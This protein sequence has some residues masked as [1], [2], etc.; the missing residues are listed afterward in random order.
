MDEALIRPGRV[1]VRARFGKA[2]KSQAQ[3]LFTKFFP[4]PTAAAAAAPLPD[5]KLAKST[6]SE[7]RKAAEKD[8]FVTDE[9][10]KPFLTEKFAPEVTDTTGGTT[11]APWGSRLTKEQ[12]EALAARFAEA[13]P[14]QTYSIAQLQ[15]FLMGYKKTP[16]LA[17]EHV[18][19]FVR[20]AGSAEVSGTAKV[21]FIEDENKTL[22]E[23]S[24]ESSTYWEG[25]E[26]QERE[27]K[28]FRAEKER[29]R[30]DSMK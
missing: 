13:I 5:L 23:A 7:S 1:D 6:E 26:E 17:V 24:K 11:G 28:E 16:E 4:Q 19:E 3:E 27:R 8:E 10:N 21:D 22:T 25:S 9:E 20:R 2:T 12:T 14:D 29:A 18:D 15:G 30:R